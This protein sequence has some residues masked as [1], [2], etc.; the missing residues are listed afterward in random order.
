MRKIV[1][2]LGVIMMFG[3]FLG[4]QLTSF[5][6][7][8]PAAQLT[9][10]L[11][12]T[13]GV[14]G[15]II[16][17][18]Q[19]D[20]TLWRIS[21]ISGVPLQELRALNNLVGDELISPGDTLLLG[22]GGPAE[23]VTPA[24][25]ALPTQ[26]PTITPT[27]PPGY[28]TVCVLLYEDVNG[29]AFR[30][31][32]EP[33]IPGGAISVSDRFGQTSLT[34]YTEAGENPVCFEDLPEGDYNVSVAVPEGYNPTTITNYAL[35]LLGGDETHIGFGAQLTSQMLATTATSAENGLSPWLGI[36]GSLL[37]VLGMGLGITAW[38]MSK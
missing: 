32:E 20:D 15:R 21:A 31:E 14:D 8:A 9:P 5:G 3:W 24:E 11:T 26:Q 28:G 34:A 22:F 17:I 37:L 12:P 19:P 18:V 23:Q 13:P 16:Y 29:D 30:Q 1:L 4:I 2:L 38:R 27:P 35:P 36:V 6:H 10:F 25:A 33:A 7:A